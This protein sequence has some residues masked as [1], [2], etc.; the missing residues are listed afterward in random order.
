MRGLGEGLPGIFTGGAAEQS[1]ISGLD[2]LLT[3]RAEPRFW[4]V[5]IWTAQE[6]R[7]S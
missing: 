2:F 4:A 6:I 1:V 5:P 3:P 7:G